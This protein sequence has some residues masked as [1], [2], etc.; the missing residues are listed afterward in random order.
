MA[1][2]GLLI[3]LNGF[4]GKFFKHVFCLML[5]NLSIAVASPEQA[6]I[7]AMDGPLMG[8]RFNKRL[9][10]PS[11]Q[12]HVLLFTKNNSLDSR[13]VAWTENSGE[14][15][16]AFPTSRMPFTVLDTNGREIE[17]LPA[18][19]D[20]SMV[21]RLSIRPLIYVPARKND[22]LEIAAAAEQVKSP[23]RVRG[24]QTVELQCT[25]TNPLDTDL[26]FTV[27]EPASNAV[28]KPGGR[29]TVRKSVDVGRPWQPIRVPVEGMGIVQQVE[30]ISENPLKLEV[31]PELS[32]SITLRLTNPTRS[33]FRGEGEIQLVTGE[34]SL[35]E[36]FRFEVAMSP[37]ES[38]KVLRIPL[39]FDGVLPYPVKVSITQRSRLELGKVFTL[40]STEPTQFAP[41]MPFESASATEIPKGYE[42]RSQGGSYWQLTA[43]LPAEGV[44]NPETGTGILVYSFRPD[45]ISI[46]IR[47][48]EDFRQDIMD[49]P[50]AYG[51]WVFSDESNNFVTCGIRDA[52]GKIYQPDPVPLD[53]K[54]WRYLRFELP[55]TMRPP[56]NWESIIEVV[57]AGENGNGAIYFNYP[58]LVYEFPE[59]GEPT[60]VIEQAGDELEIIDRRGDQPI[61]IDAVN[62]VPSP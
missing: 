36:P 41:L 24:P 46:R 6:I 28:I 32:R 45:G 59:I 12:D 22:Y 4:R 14:R 35:P 37:K 62:L 39:N 61:E 20:F 47:P 5:A 49:V 43:G 19:A 48:E 16:A 8:Y 38:E 34:A 10:T 51:I 42:G 52:T 2:Y 9:A 1:S 31:W 58:A 40:A 53:W 25:F 26:F 23:L 3:D 44:P 21:V 17:T 60:D 27:E 56:L 11:P 7:D 29:Y 18:P 54:G 55:D 50:T 57:F 15:F 13:I 33:P 30:I